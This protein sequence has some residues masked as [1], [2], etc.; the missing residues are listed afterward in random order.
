MKATELMKKY[1]GK[2]VSAFEPSTTESTDNK[3]GEIHYLEFPSLEAFNN[4]RAD[5][6]LLALKELRKRAILSSSVY[7]SEKS[8]NYEKNT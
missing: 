5:S 7:V 3:I 6:E 8:V 1:G 4:Y 2:I